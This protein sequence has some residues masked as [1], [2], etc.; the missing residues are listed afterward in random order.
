MRSL[1]SESGSGGVEDGLVPDEGVA[2]DHFQSVAIGLD[3][4]GSVR[5]AHEIDSSIGDEGGGLERFPPS[6]CSR[7]IRDP[8][9]PEWLSL[10]R[11]GGEGDS[12]V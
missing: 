1:S 2:G 5:T 3:D 4:K 12:A 9:L 11:L 6:A 7:K 10:S 8:L